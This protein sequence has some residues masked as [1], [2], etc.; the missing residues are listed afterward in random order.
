MERSAKHGDLERSAGHRPARKLLAGGRLH[1]PATPAATAAEGD[2]RRYAA[3]AESEADRRQLSHLLRRGR[4]LARP[5]RRASL[6][7]Q[8]GDQIEGLQN[9]ARGGP[10]L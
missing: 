8:A 5:W 7:R 9:A 4:D 2:Q 10:L 3:A 6:I 1:L